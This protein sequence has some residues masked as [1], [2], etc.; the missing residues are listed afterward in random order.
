M[1]RSIG[2]LNA[3]PRPLHGFTLVELLVVIAIIG[4]LVAILLPAIQA[5]R[6]AARRSACQN[7]IRQIGLALLNHESARSSLPVG[8]RSRVTYGMSWWVE[9]LPFLELSTIGDQL[10]RKSPHCGTPGGNLRN[11]KAIDGLILPAAICPSSA[12]PPFHP[13]SGVQVMMPHYVGIAGAT[14]HDG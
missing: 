14:S 6:E 5:A 12:I 1:K 13:V 8:A 7:N 10:D 2:K 11:A 9:L 3:S 4:V